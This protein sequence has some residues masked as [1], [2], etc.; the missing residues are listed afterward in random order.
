MKSNNYI[1]NPFNRIAGF[2]S[3]LIGLAGF[4]ITTYLAYLTGTHFIGF[5]KIVFARDSAYWVFLAENLS[6]W[7]FA[8]IFFFI[9]GFVLSRSKIRIIDV[10]GTVLFARIPLIAAPLIRLMPFFYS[11]GFQSW[12]MYF[13]EGVYYLSLIWTIVLLYNAYKVSCNLKHE[14]LIISF[15]INLVLS[16]VSTELVIKYII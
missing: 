8:S 5:R 11:F 16:E 12:Q 13:I 7:L 1:Y 6:S 10:F 2:Q 4:L 9:L 15:M 14:R 3:L